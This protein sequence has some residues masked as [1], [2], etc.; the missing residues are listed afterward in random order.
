MKNTI[1]PI[2]LMALF[3][4]T[5]V[6]T[7]T[8]MVGTTLKIPVSSL[9]GGGN[10]PT[11]TDSG[12]G[13]GTGN[14]LLGTSI[15][16]SLVGSSTSASFGNGA[17]FWYQL[18]SNVPDTDGDGIPDN[19]DNCIEKPNPLQLDT[20]GDGYGNVCDPDF[21][22]DGYCTTADFG[23]WLGVFRGGTPPTGVTVND[24]DL[25]GDGNVTTA[26]FGIW[27]NC[28]RTIQVP[29]PSGLVP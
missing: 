7:A 12:G 22:N 19:Q 15:G 26:D 5:E 14:F 10:V 1:I 16:Q 18:A 9:N 20:N 27:L 4:W 8:E 3:L 11:L 13:P 23:I 6:V 2:L 17:G 29:G 28:F 25:T 21:N 24:L